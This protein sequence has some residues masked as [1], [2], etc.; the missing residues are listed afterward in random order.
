[1]IRTFGNTSSR[2]GFVFTED[3]YCYVTRPTGPDTPGKLS[4]R[5]DLLYIGSDLRP[6]RSLIPGDQFFVST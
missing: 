4:H 5:L 3:P 2:V 1:M 6:Q